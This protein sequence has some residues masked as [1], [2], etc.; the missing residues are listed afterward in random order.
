MNGEVVETLYL[1]SRHVDHIV[2]SA[3]EKN[4]KVTLWHHR[5]GHLSE[6]DMKILQSY[7]TLT[8]MKA[9]S[10]DFCEN[11]VFGKQKRVSN[12]KDDKEKKSKK[13]DLVYINI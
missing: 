1:L 11:C 12:M 2:S 8:I 6:N 4:Q 10:F 5:L 7:D 9:C 3:A 13:L